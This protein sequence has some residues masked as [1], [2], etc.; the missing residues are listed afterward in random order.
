MGDTVN[1]PNDD[2]ENDPLKVAL[3]FPYRMTSE[4]F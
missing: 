4:D 1:S 3:P 2:T